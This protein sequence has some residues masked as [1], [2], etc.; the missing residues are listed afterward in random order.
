M[1]FYEKIKS[2]TKKYRAW[3]D[4]NARHPR[5]FFIR[6]PKRGAISMLCNTPIDTN[7]EK[8][9]IL[10]NF[11]EINFKMVAIL[12]FLTIFTFFIQLLKFQYQL[13]CSLRIHYSFI[14][15]SFRFLGSIFFLNRYF[16][17]H[18]LPHHQGL[19]KPQQ[20][21]KNRLLQCRNFQLLLKNQQ[22]FLRV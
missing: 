4:L 21:L 7:M 11:N 20:Q 15:N 1:I 16:F 9:F 22:R 5:F 10:E 6:K 19:R 2:L 14:F 12:F 3:C 8:C 18:K 17:D 13:E